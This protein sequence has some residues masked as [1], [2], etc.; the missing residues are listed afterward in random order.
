[1]QGAF[2]ADGSARYLGFTGEHSDRWM[3]DAPIARCDIRKPGSSRPIWRWRKVD[4]DAYLESRLIP[5]GHPN[6]FEL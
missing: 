1:M 4:L 2:D 6:P 5:P 3:D